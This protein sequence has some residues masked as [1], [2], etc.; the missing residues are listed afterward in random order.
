MY[1]YHLV[2]D[3]FHGSKLVPLNQMDRF[4][5]LYTNHASKYKGR[6]EL[7]NT[8]IPKLNCKWNDVI[9]FSCID[10]KIVA[11]EI[12]KIKPDL[13]LRRAKYFKIHIDQISEKYR[14]MIFSNYPKEK[15]N[16]FHILENEMTD[17]TKEAYKELIAVPEHTIEYWVRAH[18]NNQPLLWFAFMPH[19]FINET[20]ETSGF[21]VV[22]LN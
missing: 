13:K 11:R 6:E 15:N 18:E 14:A 22:E 3:P 1:I 9:H 12:K 2:P 21:E 20:V 4:S 10:P 8:M 5:D 17:L 7:M 19:I 16:T